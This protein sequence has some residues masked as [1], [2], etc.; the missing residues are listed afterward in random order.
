[1]LGTS[2]AAIKFSS[3][4]DLVLCSSI[5]AEHSTSFPKLDFKNTGRVFELVFTFT[6]EGDVSR[7]FSFFCIARDVRGVLYLFSD[8]AD[9][10]LI[11]LEFQEAVVGC[12]CDVNV[13]G[14]VSGS[15]K[16]GL[17]GLG[18]G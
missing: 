18:A 11:V 13:G 7:D 16:G 2:K 6:L 10:I 12:E 17:C 3:T 15:N 8:T 1:M 4:K 5:I 9:I 14:G